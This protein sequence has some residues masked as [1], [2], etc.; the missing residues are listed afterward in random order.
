MIAQIFCIVLKCYVLLIK[1]YISRYDLL[2]YI[3]M[4]DLNNKSLLPKTKLWWER[5]GRRK[6]FKFMIYVLRLAYV[7]TIG[8]FF[9]LNWWKWKFILLSSNNLNHSI[10]ACYSRFHFRNKVL[11][12]VVYF[13][14]TVFSY[15]SSV[16]L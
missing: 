16:L 14:C 13:W 2:L 9:M 6:Y 1:H 7:C 3:Y 15:I 5:T 12:Q 11:D 4:V 8:N 10:F